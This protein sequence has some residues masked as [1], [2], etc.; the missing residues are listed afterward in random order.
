MDFLLLS[1]ISSVLVSILLKITTR[2]HWDIRQVIAGGYAVAAALCL[3]FLNANPY[4]L[5][6]GAPSQA[7]WVLLALGLLL[8]SL[9]L[10][11]A[12]SVEQVGIVRTDAAQRLSLLVPLAAAFLLF[13]ETFTWLKG[14]GL[15]LGFMAILLIV[16]KEKSALKTPRAWRWP[17]LVFFGMGVID[18]LF[19]QMSALAHMAFADVLFAV[20]VLALLLLSLYLI[21]RHAQQKLVWHW[22]SLIGALL[23]GTFNF[24]NILFYIKAHQ[25]MAKEPALVFASMNM[26]VII[27]G[28]LV[29]AG[30]FKEKLTR[31]NVL[32]LVLALFAVAVLALARF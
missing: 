11:L 13:G 16:H 8:P 20:F 31:S 12:K 23:L 1:I 21:V 3:L 10:I 19:K 18:I 27:L 6:Q 24:A 30:L 17:V 2:T 25:S 32:G 4:A 29:G 15:I 9:F 5:M 26:G 14:T 28:T 22:H 7:W